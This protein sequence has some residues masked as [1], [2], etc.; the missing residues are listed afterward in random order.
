MVARLV[1]LAA[2]IVATAISA[3]PPAAAGGNYAFLGGTRAERGQV[4]AELEASLFDWSIVPEQIT[5]RIAP[6]LASSAEAGTIEPDSG[7]LDAGRFGAAGV[8]PV[9]AIGLAAC[10]SLGACRVRR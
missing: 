2:T 7:L 8:E 1:C 4:R 5:I 10:R 6:G 9:A 3:Q